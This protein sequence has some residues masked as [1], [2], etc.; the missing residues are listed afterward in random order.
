M[1]LRKL[2]VSEHSSTRK[3]WEE[4]FPEDG[5][6]FLDYYYFMKVR[7]NQIYTIESDGDIRSMLQL[8]PYA[9][10]IGEK[11]H[12]CNYIV[13]VATQ[14]KYRGRG[15]MRE[16]LKKSMQDMYG[17][18]E[19]FT[20][21]M[22]AAA[23][24]Y[25][26]YD[27]RFIYSQNRGALY[28]S[29]TPPS[30]D[31]RDAVPGDCRAMAGLFYECIA[32][33]YQVYAL[34]DDRY[35]QTMILEQQSEDGGVRLMEQE[36]RIVGMFAYAR[37]G[38]TLEIREPLYLPAFEGEYQKAVG[39][40]RGGSKAAAKI[41][42][43]ENTNES[44]KK[45]LIMARIIHLE[46]MLEAMKVKNGESLECSFAV[47]DTILTKNSKVIKLKG[48]KENSHICVKETEDSEGVIT[49]SALAE[50]L[51]GAKTVQEAVREENVDISERLLSELEKLQPLNKVFLNE[52]V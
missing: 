25:T 1:Q 15:F 48:S 42:A 18:K 23:A 20:F 27:F 9:L 36:G 39:R 10:Q 51:F 12:V 41:F 11:Q 38:D 4:V 16:L 52:T 8:N 35:Y 14:E 29:D 43:G 32:G 17:Q 7:D 50:I 31:I 49:I 34:R 44:R 3:L 6:E 40:L 47:L 33:D 26:P 22:P 21:L 46:T 2:D 37:D 45:P 19:P 28:G 13:A 24:I 30:V 5:K